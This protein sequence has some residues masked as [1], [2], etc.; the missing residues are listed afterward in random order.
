MTL[1]QISTSK[2]IICTGNPPEAV[3][4]KAHTARAAQPKIL[5]AMRTHHLSSVLVAGTMLGLPLTAQDIQP[6]P[7]APTPAPAAPQPAAEAVQQTSGSEESAATIPMIPQQ[8][9]CRLMASN[10]VRAIYRGV[11]ESGWGAAPA[12]HFTVIETLAHKSYEPEGDP[13]L[14]PGTL[15]GVELRRDIPGQPANVVDSILVMRPGEEAVMRMDHLY[16]LDPNY[17]GNLRVC[18]RFQARMAAPAATPGAAP[19]APYGINPPASTQQPAPSP[20]ARTTSGAAGQVSTHWELDS[21]GHVRER[22]FVNGEEVAPPTLQQEEAPASSTPTQPEQTASPA[23]P[24]RVLPEEGDGDD[25]IVET[26]PTPAASTTPAASQP[27]A[28]TGS[29]DPQG[30]PP[31]T[32]TDYNPA[33]DSF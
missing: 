27:P 7:E 12:A 16:M 32:S 5:K 11:V 31:T 13:M 21:Q 30:N 23:V 3:L 15:I 20:T 2:V 26:P 18:A 22:I 1:I 17:Q 10:T 14:P 4:Y 9:N 8:G 25:T 33:Q 28:A 6:I 19:V 29:S 24:D